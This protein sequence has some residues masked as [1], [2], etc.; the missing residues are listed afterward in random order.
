MTQENAFSIQKIYRYPVKSFGP[1]EVSSVE[2]TSGGLVGDRRYAI[3]DVSTG[4]ICTAKML[5]KFGFM[6]DFSARYL[7]EPK[8]GEPLPPIEITFPDGKV[9]NSTDADL[10]AALSEVFGI[11]VRLVT[12][13]QSTPATE[14]MWRVVEGHNSTEWTEQRK[15][16]EVDGQDWIRFELAGAVPEQEGFQS[17]MDLSPIHIY[18]R[19]TQNYFETQEPDLDFDPMRFR[20]NILLD[21]PDVGLVEQTWSGKSISF[22]DVKMKMEYPTVRCGMPSL[23]QKR[24]G[25]PRSR[26]TLQTI[27]RLNTLEVE[28]LGPGKWACAGAYASIEK[29]G[30]LTVGAELVFADGDE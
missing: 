14:A 22:D 28:A 21:G 24:V 3:E 4:D 29:S 18:T 11:E 25:L 10:N 2:V 1:E 9:M 15:L 27:A 7:E 6:L 5:Q 30:K 13:V 20:P 16:G 19:S 12:Q 8:L 23:G 17:F 26:K